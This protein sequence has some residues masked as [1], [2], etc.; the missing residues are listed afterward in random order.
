[1]SE[2]TDLNEDVDK[3]QDS[4][5]DEDRRRFLL[6]STCVLGGVGAACALTPLC[7][8]LVT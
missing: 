7:S 1:M 8:I 2:I 4:P 6:T 5:L 3:K